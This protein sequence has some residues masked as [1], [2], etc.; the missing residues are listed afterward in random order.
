MRTPS[1]GG[2]RL[3]AGSQSASREKASARP[4]PSCS[5]IPRTREGRSGKAVPQQRDRPLVAVMRNQI[6]DGMPAH[7][8]NALLAV[9]MAQHGLRRDDPF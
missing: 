9:G 3:A 5:A 2:R 4:V 1:I 6:A 7:P 8:N